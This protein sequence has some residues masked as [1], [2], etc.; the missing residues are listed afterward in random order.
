MTSRASLPLLATLALL[1]AAPALA[2]SETEGHGDRTNP[3]ASVA[4]DALRNPPSP[5][6]PGQQNT[7]LDARR[8]RAS[9]LMGADIYSSENYKI[10]SVEDLVFTPGGELTVVVRTGA[11]LGFGGKMVTVPLRELQHSERWVLPGGTAENLKQR[12]EYRP[13]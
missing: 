7:S 12:P 3:E 8:W 1:G 9:T 10:G 11:T 6:L 5:P 2:Q 13:G 4:R